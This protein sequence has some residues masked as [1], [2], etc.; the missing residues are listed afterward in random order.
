[1]K[2]PKNIE[3]L[4]ELAKWVNKNQPK[5]LEVNKDQPIIKAFTVWCMGKKEV[6]KTFRGIPIKTS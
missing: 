6:F 2:I 3:T 5:T 1:M 4:A